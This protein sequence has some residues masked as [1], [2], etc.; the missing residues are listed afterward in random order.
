MLRN[1]RLYLRLIG[2]QVRSQAQYRLS[3]VVD[4]LQTALGSMMGFLSLVLVLQKFGNVAGWTIWDLAFLYGTVEFSFGIMDM[5]FSGFDPPNFGRQV[6]L[7]RLDQILLRPVNVSL[8]IM[9][10]EFLL[11]RLG[12]I[13]QGLI[14]LSIAAHMTNLQWTAGKII[15]LPILIGSQVLFFGGLFMIGAAWTF[16]SVESIE[17]MNIFTYGGA[18][19][20]SYPMTIYPYPLRVIFTYIIPGMFLNYYPALY[21]LNKPDPLGF[22]WFAP[23]LAPVAGAL[24]FLVAIACWNL[25]LRA[26][27]STGT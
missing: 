9:G 14:I 20:M 3:F 18:E 2:I 15:Y 1:V 21:F 19:M 17:A 11:R 4:L 6:R 24:V 7:G 27:Q 25:G 5:F 13:F 12:R 8:Q 10:S 23:F 22:P 26:Y 16:W